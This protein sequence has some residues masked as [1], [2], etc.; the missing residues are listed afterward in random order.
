[1]NTDERFARVRVRRTLL[2]LM[3]SFNGRIVEGL[4]RTAR[5]LREDASALEMAAAELLRTAS[6]DATEP[7]SPLRV[8]ILRSAPPAVRRRALR[9]WIGRGRGDLRRLEMAHL[10]AVEA[11]LRGERG[12]RVAELPGGSIVSRKLGRLRFHVKRVEKGDADD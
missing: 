4:A 8:E 12:G 2:P 11:L 3:Q 10:L 5:L 1:M 6:E 9:Q 7:V